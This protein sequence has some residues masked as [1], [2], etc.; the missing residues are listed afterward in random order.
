MVGDRL[1][2]DVLP[3]QRIGMHGIWYTGNS[4][5]RN[6]DDYEHSLEILMNCYKKSNT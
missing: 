1:Q 6:E 2:L 5:S 3:A 4:K